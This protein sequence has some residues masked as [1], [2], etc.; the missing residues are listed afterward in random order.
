MNYLVKIVIWTTLV[1]T[2]LG[3]KLPPGFKKCNLKQ[4]SSQDCLPKAIES[5]IKQMNRP[6]K[7]LGVLGLQPLVIP[8]LIIDA[9]SQFLVAQQIYKDMK[10]SGFN[11]TSCSKAEFDY[12]NKTLNLECVVP[13]FRMDF[14]YE[15]HGK[16]MMVTIYGNGTGW[17]LFHN[18]EL[19]L[20]FKFGEYEKKGN[21]YFNILSQQLRM[22]PT[23]IDFDLQNLFDGDEESTLRMKKILKENAL[24]IYNEV[25]AGYEEAYGK[26]FAYV[27]EKILE[28][29]PVPEIFG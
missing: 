5:A 19:G 24:D 22:Q 17:L 6:I 11:E 14:H 26:V 1:A 4:I 23:D 16:V 25:R 9:G 28:K 10:L 27:F 29:V 7:K 2:A 12:K 8:S 18:N 13:N 3:A 21:T 20:S 15:V